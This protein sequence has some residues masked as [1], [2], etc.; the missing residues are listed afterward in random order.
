M[1][2]ITT[3]ALVCH[4]INK[5]LVL[6]DVVLGGLRPNEAVVEIE[7]TGVCHTDL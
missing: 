1:S 6:E 4:E 2:T 5:P 7:A 3:T